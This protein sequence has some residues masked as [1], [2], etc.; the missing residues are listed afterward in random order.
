LLLV[1]NLQ[2]IYN[3]Y[4][5]RVKVNVFSN[6]EIHIPGVNILDYIEDN[7]ITCENIDLHEL[8]TVKHPEIEDSP[9]EYVHNIYNIILR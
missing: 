8:E 1:I 3:C 4:N 6:D 5:T 7:N 2:L 9:T